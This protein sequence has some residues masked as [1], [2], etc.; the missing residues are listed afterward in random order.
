MPANVTL[1]V[2]KGQLQGQAF[3]FA[4]RTTCIIGRADDCSPR[5]PT[6]DHHQTISRHH[7]LLD[8]N[9][10]DARVRDFGSLNGTY[11]NGTKIGQRHRG[12]TPEEGAQMTFPEF[13]LKDGDEIELGKTVFRVSV[14]V[15]VL[16]AEC[17][18]EVPE[19]EK[20]AAERA[21][22]V[23]QC[24]ACRMKTVESPR[25]EPPPPKAKVCAQ[26]GRDVSG[27]VGEHRQGEFICARCKADP[28]G[29]AKH[30]MELSQA[31]DKDLGALRDYRLLKELGR[32][33]MGAVFLARH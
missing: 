13:D 15:P 24:A 9:P 10:P 23:Y 1:T 20:A 7:C 3:A 8:V 26:C 31:G 28:A 25:T 32:G 16:C 33:G 14:F 17:G 4:E 30:L 5:L 29:I 21:A 2:T 12:M 27:E 18:A 22:G 6:D 19:A 11:V